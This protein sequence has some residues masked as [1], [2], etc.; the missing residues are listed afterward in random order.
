MTRMTKC[1]PSFV[2]LSLLVGSP[3]VAEG[4]L[5][6]MAVDASR[7]TE[8]L[9]QVR[10]EV[11]VSPGALTLF[12]PKWIPG[13]HGPSGP[14]SNLVGLELTTGGQELPWQRDPVDMFAFHLEVPAGAQRLEIAADFLLTSE[15]GRFTSGASATPALAMLNWNSVALFPRG[16]D[17]QTVRVR[18][19]LTLPGGWSFA[20]A[21]AVA[22]QDGSRVHFAE[23]PLATLVD[24]PVLVGAHLTNLDLGQVGNAPHWLSIAADRAADLKDAATVLE[25]MKRLVAESRALFG[26]RHYNS[27]RFLLAASDHVAHFGLEHHESSDNRLEAEILNSDEG[28]RA[29]AGL[30]AHEMVH[31]WNGK[32]RRP[33][34][35]LSS[36]FHRPM[37]GALLWVY[38]GLTQHL[39]MVLPVRAGFWKPEEYRERVAETA[40]TLDT[41][42][43]RK[44]RPLGDTATAVQVVFE[45][46]GEGWNRR[47]GAD[48]YDES[49]FLWLDVDTLLRE[50]SGNKINLDGF[51]QR[52]HGGSD[53]GPT[54]KPYTREQLVAELSSL[55]P[56]DWE[57]LFV[58]RVDRVAPRL[59]MQGLERS[60]WRLVYTAEANTAIKER[61]ARRER[62]DWRFSLGIIV[63][64]EGEVREVLPDSPAGRAG[65]VEG[66]KLMAVDGY[67]W[68]PRSVDAA[69]LAAR[70]RKTPIEFL[71]SFGDAVATYR[72]DY[73]DGPRYPH[74]ERIEGRPDV[75]AEILSARAA[76]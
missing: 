41:Q 2:L 42:A 72:L 8:K 40:A 29:M 21:L 30:L 17:G 68:N 48:F 44:W 14:V 27:Y 39:G 61:E 71:A 32:H 64:N 35:L 49:I 45:S 37:Q 36:D 76:P 46:P 38:E 12:Y 53:T 66:S 18:P 25:P 16:G 56:H 7:V 3:A 15:G 58:E 60:G 23:V 65:M 20:S 9:L 57:A 28:R 59:P 31:S 34:G 62:R 4:T 74:L 26:S 52:F 67:L 50:K 13:Q 43:G 1:V 63:N 11:P 22:A 24:S 55:V 33:E 19:S 10:S 47:R 51:C 73:H 75:L 70:S 5:I 6:T 69:I 54:V